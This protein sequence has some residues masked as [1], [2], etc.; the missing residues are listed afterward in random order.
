MMSHLSWLLNALVRGSAETFKCLK[1]YSDSAPS[2]YISIT[3]LQSTDD[4]PR[5]IRRF[6]I[7]GGSFVERPGEPE[8]EYHLLPTGQTQVAAEYA[9][10]TPTV[11]DSAGR[12]WEKSRL[13]FGSVGKP[14]VPRFLFTG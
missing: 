12:I 10:S 5:H 8:I 13:F 9:E 1:P 14:V 4:S 2:L 11:Q 6:F 3:P 7:L